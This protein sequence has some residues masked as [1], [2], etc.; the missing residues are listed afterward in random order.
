[1][2]LTENKNDQTSSFWFKK[3]QNITDNFLIQFTFKIE[4]KGADGFAFVFQNNNDQIIGKGG[5]G[6]GYENI[7]N[8]IAIEFDTYQNIDTSNDPNGNHISVQTRG[9][10]NNSSNHDYSLGINYTKNR[11]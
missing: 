2:R 10:N 7:P 6:L 11:M 5:S 1:V 4:N 8:S 3:K 9:E